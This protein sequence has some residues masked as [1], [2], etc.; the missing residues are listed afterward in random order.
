MAKSIPGQL[1]MFDLP[2]W[3]DSPSAT[4]SPESVDG[5]LPSASPDGPTTAP[6]GRGAAR[7]SR[8]ASQAKAPVQTIQGTCGLTS[9]ASSPPTGPLS[10]W[11]SRLRERLATV[12]STECALIWK[13]QATPA[14]GSISRLSRSAPRTF[15]SASTGSPSTWPTP[16]STVT[17]AK[18]RPPITTGR[19]ATDPQISTADVAVHLY[20]ATWPTPTKADGDGGHTMG[21]ASATGKRED[22]SKITV[23]L[24]GVVKIVGTWAT[25]TT[26]D[27]KDVTDPATWN[28][29]DERNRYDQVGRQ[30]FLAHGP[31][32]SGSLEPTAKPGALNPAFVCWLMGYPTEWDDFAPTAT[33][34]SRK[35]R[36]K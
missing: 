30:V 1:S 7:A 5:A 25:P 32:P 10:S 33:P 13:V 4:S 27:W 29:T 20:A 22:G 6:S 23:S 21:T 19:K 26:R 35:S 24:P 15:A 17:D 11:E 18:P 34:S 16:N 36:Q 9:I 2:I 8:S 12:G 14:G 3:Q 28:C 31:A